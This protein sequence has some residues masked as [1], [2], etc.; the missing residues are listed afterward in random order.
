MLEKQITNKQDLIKTLQQ[1]KIKKVLG[2]DIKNEDDLNNLI[3]DAKQLLRSN[4]EVSLFL[5]TT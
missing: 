1:A 5:I 3:R 2:K 4:N